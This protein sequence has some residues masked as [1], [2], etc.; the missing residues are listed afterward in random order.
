MES[1]GA[2]DVRGEEPSPLQI[3]R[4]AAPGG[5]DDWVALSPRATGGLC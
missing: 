1:T 4:S 5:P 2:F 3:A